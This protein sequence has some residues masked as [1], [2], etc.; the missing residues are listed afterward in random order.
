MTLHLLP[1]GLPGRL[2]LVIAGGLFLALAASA[3]IQLQ[4]RGEA[5]FMAGGVQTAQRFAALVQLLD[6]MTPEERQRVAT[7]LEN[8]RQS[9]RFIEEEEEAGSFP[10]EEDDRSSYL[11]E[12]LE[13]RL[14]GRSLKVKV[15]GEELPATP[16][17]ADSVAKATLGGRPTS[18]L[19]VSLPS[20]AA[21]LHPDVP[22]HGEKKPASAAR[23]PAGEASSPG[24]GRDPAQ[25]DDGK[26]GGESRSRP[27]KGER[28]ENPI[29]CTGPDCTWGS[30]SHPVTPRQ[31]RTVRVKEGA[32]GKESKEGKDSREGKNSKDLRHPGKWGLSTDAL[33]PQGVFFVARVRLA[34]GVWAEFHQHLPRELFTW[35]ERLWLSL[36][37]LL[38]GVLMITFLAVRLVM[39]PLEV[40]SG[41]VEQVGRGA[42]LPPLPENGPWEVQSAA[43]S[44]NAMRARLERYL[45]ERTHLLAALSHDLK[46]P[47]TRMR[48]RAEMMPDGELR[49]KTLRVHQGHPGAG[50]AVE[51]GGLA[52]VGTAH[53]GD[54]WRHV[55]F[56]RKKGV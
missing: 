33:V 34:D 30:D 39:R 2:A 21:P 44:F 14:G 11:R 20:P 28:G 31:A 25:D 41:A 53:Q 38:A 52:H 15:Y 5:L 23:E 7:A 29:A 49:D 6:P 4:E 43:R 40:L 54:E 16:H 24:K 42:P 46:T 47:I 19:A 12:L 18:A 36:G 10:Q 22:P 45:Q 48:L 8:P 35:P 56:F 37:I 17:P 13:R 50:Q 26:E 55:R 32:K 51:Q 3:A 1:R 27:A 9:I